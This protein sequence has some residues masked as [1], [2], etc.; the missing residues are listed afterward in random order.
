LIAA[1]AVI[2]EIA[3]SPP[4]TNGHSYE[5]EVVITDQG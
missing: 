3:K 2:T 5:T 1:R 4:D